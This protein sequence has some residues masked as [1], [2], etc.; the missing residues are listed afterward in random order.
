MG[1]GDTEAAGKRWEDYSEA[2]LLGTSARYAAASLQGDEPEAERLGNS[3]KTVSGPAL[4]ATGEAAAN[5]AAG[6]LT[7]GMSF[8][9]MAAIA[10]GTNVGAGLGVAVGQQV[11]ETGELNSVDMIGIDIGS[12][13]FSSGAEGAEGAE[14]DRAAEAGEAGEA[15]TTGADTDAAAAA[16]AA[17]APNAARSAS[18]APGAV[19]AVEAS[20]DPNKFDAIWQAQ[21]LS[22]A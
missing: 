1:G 11:M 14:A 2:S 4:L 18:A 10:V 8:P 13:S 5:I 3:V 6:V 21:A 22:L 16:N 9:V 7:V 19:A 20:T 17:A 15:T 12:V